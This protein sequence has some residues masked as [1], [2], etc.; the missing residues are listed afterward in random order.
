MDSW[1]NYDIENKIL[2]THKVA[3]L[4]S[5][6]IPEIPTQLLLNPKDWQF[7]LRINSLLYV[8]NQKINK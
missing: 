8:T 1:N 3:A 4:N 2:E 5:K 7:F 6:Q